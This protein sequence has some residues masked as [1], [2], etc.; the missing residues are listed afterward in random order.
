MITTTNVPPCEC[1]A[2]HLLLSLRNICGWGRLVGGRCTDPPLL[3]TP[4]P[5]SC[6]ACSVPPSFDDRHGEEKT[7]VVAHSLH[8]AAD[9]IEKVCREVGPCP[10]AVYGGPGAVC[11]CG[12]WGGGG[13]LSSEHG[14]QQ[15]ACRLASRLLLC[16]CNTRLCT[17]RHIGSRLTSACCFVPSHLLSNQPGGHRVP[18]P[19]AGWVGFSL[20]GA[21][22]WGSGRGW[23]VRLWLPGCTR[24]CHIA[25]RTPFASITLPC[26]PCNG[27][28]RLTPL[29][30]ALRH[31]S[32]SSPSGRSPAPAPCAATSSL[33]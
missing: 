20:W 31:L 13:A 1:V 28:L 32:H 11:V 3:R 18:V 19:Q 6:K 8:G 5:C 12:G 30:L 15:G 16:G 24:A 29:R 7:K 33:T 17:A 22:Q 2:T 25:A 21:T 23:L 27:S 14:W 10:V 4:L 26:A 9:W